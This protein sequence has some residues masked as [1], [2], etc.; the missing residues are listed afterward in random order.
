VGPTPDESEAL[1]ADLRRTARPRS[2]SI[3]Q[4]AALTRGPRS[5]AQRFV[6]V[7]DRDIVEAAKELGRVGEVA[8][9]DGW[10]TL[11]GARS[12]VMETAVRRVADLDWATWAA[13]LLRAAPAMAE[14][15]TLAA[16]GVLDLHW[17]SVAGAGEPTSDRTLGQLRVRGP[18]QRQLQALANLLTLGSVY[19]NLDAA[20]RRV[21]KGQVL[22]L[23]AFGHT[24][25]ISTSTELEDAIQRF[26]RRN[27]VHGSRYAWLGSA[28]PVRATDFD[29]PEEH[30]PQ[31]TYMDLPGIGR[32]LH[33]ALRGRDPWVPVAVSLPELAGMH[34]TLGRSLSVADAGDVAVARAAMRTV[35][36]LERQ[37]GR[38]GS[39]S[40]DGFLVHKKEPFREAF[41]EEIAGLPTDCSPE[42][43]W[44]AVARGPRRLLACSPTLVFVAL[45]LAGL[46]VRD[47][48]R[49]SDGGEA[50]L[51]GDRFEADVQEIVDASPWRPPDRLRPL[52]GMKVGPAKRPL[53][54]VDGVALVGDKLLL[55]DAKAHRMPPSLANERPGAMRSQTMTIEREAAAWKGKVS[56]IRANPGLLRVDLSGITEI[57]GLVVLPTVP[58]VTGG[59][60]LDPVVGSLLRACAVS[61]LAVAPYAEPL[62]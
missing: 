59:P 19:Q 50:N 15:F 17:R 23:D 43:A 28:G 56:T 52:V 7:A 54:D 48:Q 22:S 47:V 6:S 62:P 49:A 1:L 2:R 26:D 40:S 37:R 11:D 35:L 13:L 27:V 46:S 3:A 9:D 33:E 45:P 8:G 60:A 42:E 14:R 53:T 18:S 5:V 39:W 25:I 21:S 29:H 10:E 38:G 32:R 61:E 58:F 55:L 36:S 4:T 12:A 41:A 34:F 30:V 24:S 16:T 51:W 31:W 20:Q 57:D 44:S